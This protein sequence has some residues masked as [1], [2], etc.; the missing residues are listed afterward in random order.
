MAGRVLAG[1]Q[2]RRVDGSCCHRQRPLASPAVYNEM[3]PGRHLKLLTY[4]R[5]SRALTSRREIAARHWYRLCRSAHSRSRLFQIFTGLLAAASSILH[6]QHFICKQLKL[7]LII[8]IARTA[9]CLLRVPNVAHAAAAFWSAQ[10][11]CAR[12][13]CSKVST[14]TVTVKHHQTY[15]LA[16]L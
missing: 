6:A 1:G 13:C 9:L 4:W 15:D 10:C 16:A 7:Q 11:L 8:S 3:P 5:G 2:Y 14:P 12:L